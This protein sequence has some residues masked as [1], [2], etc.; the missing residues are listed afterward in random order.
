VRAAIQNARFE[1]PARRIT[2][3]LAPVIVRRQYRLP[4][5]RPDGN[6]AYIKRSG[7]HD[8]R[9]SRMFREPTEGSRHTRA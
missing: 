1:F 4:E 8:E 3:N 9:W 7:S 6:R 5:T 2:V